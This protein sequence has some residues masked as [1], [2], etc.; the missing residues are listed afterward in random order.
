[1]F[2]LKLLINKKIREKQGVKINK[3]PDREAGN[4]LTDT[5]A[6]LRLTLQK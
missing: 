2:I 4:Q 6:E 1:M 3:N 5:D